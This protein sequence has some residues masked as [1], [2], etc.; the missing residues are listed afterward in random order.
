MARLFSVSGTYNIASKTV[1]TTGYIALAF[2]GG[3]RVKGIR[4]TVVGAT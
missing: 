3:G 1:F 2:P 4:K